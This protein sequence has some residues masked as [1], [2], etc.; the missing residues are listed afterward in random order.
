M[1]NF[2][3]SLLYRK[4]QKTGLPP[5]TLVYTGDQ[6]QKPVHVSVMEYDEANF[7]EWTPSLTAEEC[8][9]I[10]GQPFN[11]WINI[12]GVNDLGLIERLGGCFDLHPLVLED[13]AHLEQRPKME[14][15]SSYLFIVLKMFQ[16]DQDKQTVAVE[17]VSLVLGQDYLLTFQENPG[18]I[19]D[20]IRQRLRSGKGRV[21]KMPVSFLAYL[22][23]DAIVDYYF[24]IFDSMGEVIEELE[25][26]ILQQTDH[27]TL[28]HIHRL[29]HQLI[30]LRK[31][32]WPLRE[33]LGSLER[34]ESKYFDKSTRPFLRDLY[35]HSIQVVET[36]ESFRDVLTGLLDLNLS[37]A[38]ARM[39][40]VMKVLTIIATIFIPLGFIAGV[41]GMNFKHM[42][43]LTQG[44]A[45]PYGF[46]GL[47][48][49]VVIGMLFYF[50]RKKWL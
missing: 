31:S 27:G 4:T 38:S 7:R 13:I 30:L 22:L 32:V 9:S 41:Y 19:F 50:K 18:D 21:R 2:D 39:N 29:K 3:L 46:W 5:G 36:I 14:E 28:S 8:L 12:D 40:E 26:K 6:P 24:T 44:W 1:K 42:P 10:K 33:M 34:T 45:Y 37:T 49:A 43:E 48:A 47:I 16:L 35:D 11:K 20:P 15:Y 25:E 23:I 17:Q